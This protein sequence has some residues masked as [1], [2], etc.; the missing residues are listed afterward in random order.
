M[1][2]YN[3]YCPLAHALD[4]VGE[5]WTLLIIRNLFTGPK[6]FSDLLRGLP[7]IGTNILT[8]RLKTL[9]ESG[10][11]HSRFLPPPAASSVY[12]LTAYGLGLE[13][14]LAALAQ[15][16]GKS[17]GAPQAEQVIS[18]ESVTLMLYLMFKT[19]ATPGLTDVYVVRVE[20]RHYSGQFT[21]KV[22]GPKVTVQPDAPPTDSLVLR[23]DLETIESIA[24]RLRLF[25]QAYAEGSLNLEGSEA[26]IAKL[27]AHVVG[28]G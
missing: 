26:E 9:E 22:D 18:A 19:I 2:T 4:L 12:E 20:D 28:L 1:R 10:L 8:A 27:R 21:V 7:G 24:T 13:D 17:L 5:R 23:A 16:G 3:Q 25:Q 6:R 15:W 11:I 14:V